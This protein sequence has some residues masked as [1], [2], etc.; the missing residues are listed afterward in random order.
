MNMEV[1]TVWNPK[2]EFVTVAPEG[3]FEHSSAGGFL[4]M[5]MVRESAQKVMSILQKKGVDIAELT[6]KANAEEKIS[7]KDFSFSSIQ[8]NFLFE[9]SAESFEYLNA[10]EFSQ[11]SCRDLSTLLAKYMHVGWVIYVNG[12]FLGDGIATDYDSYN[13]EESL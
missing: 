8:L 7:E 12:Q 10:V 4:L 1:T 3:G 11:Y 9:G 5:A 2:N 6:I 13:A